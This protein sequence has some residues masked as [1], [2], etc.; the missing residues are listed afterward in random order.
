MPA[1]TAPNK[2]SAYTNIQKYKAALKHLIH[3]F[4]AA[5]HGAEQVLIVV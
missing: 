5:G 3:L 2:T 4:K 1:I